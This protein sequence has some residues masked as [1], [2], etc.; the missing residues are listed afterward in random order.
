M[1]RDPQGKNKKRLLSPPRDGGENEV[2]NVQKTTD[3]FVKFQSLITRF[4]AE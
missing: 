4:K 3:F 1:A 2:E